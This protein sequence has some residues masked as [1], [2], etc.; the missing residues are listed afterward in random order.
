MANYRNVEMAFW[1]DQSVLDTYTY[2]DR[3]FY[4][5]LLT[6]PHTNL[7]GCYEVGIS[8][9]KMETGLPKATIEKLLK[10]MEEVHGVIRISKVTGEILI[11]NWYRYNWT[12]SDKFRKALLPKIEAVKDPDHK[13]YLKKVFE[14]TVSIPYPYGMDTVTVSV[15]VSVNSKYIYKGTTRDTERSPKKEPKYVNFKQRNYDFEKLEQVVM[16]A[17]ERS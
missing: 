7:C 13:K 10:R 9:M 8:I 16:E 6:N 14:D 4:L 12:R 17:Q 1:T 11:L 5:Y 15:P 3:Y 2:Q